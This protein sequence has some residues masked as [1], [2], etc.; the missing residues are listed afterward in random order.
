MLLAN[1]SSRM[2]AVQLPDGP[3]LCELDGEPPSPARVWTY[4]E[5]L[6]QTP[7]DARLREP[8]FDPSRPIAAIE[9][10]G[11]RLAVCFE[12]GAP[13]TV[14]HLQTEIVHGLLRFE[15]VQ[16]TGWNYLPAVG[17]AEG[18]PPG[19]VDAGEF[20][21]ALAARGHGS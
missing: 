9:L 18:V 13:D 21:E 7:P 10:C 20:F 6:L 2:N 14:L 11:S 3:W 12:P 15:R 17:N 1:R 5:A 19:G 16:L 8:P 4:P